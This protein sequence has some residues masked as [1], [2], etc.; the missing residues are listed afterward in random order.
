MIHEAIAE[1]IGSVVPG[2]AFSETGGSNIFVDDL[3][4]DPIIAV[5]VYI[6]PGPESDSKLPYDSPGVQI[7]IRGTV[8]PRVAL[9]LWQAIYSELHALRAVTLPGGWYLVACLAE[10]SSPVRMGADEAG[11]QI[12]G[13]NLRTEVL[14]PTVFRT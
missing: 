1:Y 9:R 7:L 6:T 10:Q 3:P 12:Y 2:L 8:D 11:R 14:N 4:S 5:G 13:L